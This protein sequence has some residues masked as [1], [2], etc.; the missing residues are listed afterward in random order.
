MACSSTC[1][2]LAPTGRANDQFW[3]IN[4]RSTGDRRE[5]LQIARLSLSSPTNP[6]PRT[7]GDHDVFVLRIR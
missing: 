6:P 7:I 4:R 1:K 2:P 3:R 5:P